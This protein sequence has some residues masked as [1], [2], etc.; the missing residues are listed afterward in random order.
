MS[1]FILVSE[2]SA[3]LLCIVRNQTYTR[4]RGRAFTESFDFPPTTNY[5]ETQLHSYSEKP[6]KPACH[7]LDFAGSQLAATSSSNARGRTITIV[8]ASLIRLGLDY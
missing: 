2:R 1:H 4:T 3:R 8:R 7:G 5:P 6:R